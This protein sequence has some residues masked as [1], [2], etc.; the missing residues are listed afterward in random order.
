MTRLLRRVENVAL[1]VK[2]LTDAASRFEQKLPIDDLGLI[3][4]YALALRQADR[5]G[6][7]YRISWIIS[8]VPIIISL[9]IFITSSIAYARFLS[10]SM[11]RLRAQRRAGSTFLSHYRAVSLAQRS[12]YAT[13]GVVSIVYGLWFGLAAWLAIDIQ[14]ITTD[15]KDGQLVLLIPLYVFSFF[16]R[17]CVIL[18]ELG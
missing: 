8:L 9:T 3:N 13:L 6:F 18:M 2:N 15:P 16:P 10:N 4:L 14:R 12:N 7:T 5:A 1:L 17:L 11:E